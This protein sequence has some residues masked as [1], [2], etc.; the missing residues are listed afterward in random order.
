MSPL[1]EKFKS[2]LIFLYNDEFNC[3]SH[4]WFA[5]LATGELRLTCKINN[6]NFMST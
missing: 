5:L 6:D 4:K 2:C 1:L 3:V